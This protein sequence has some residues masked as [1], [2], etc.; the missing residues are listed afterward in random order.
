MVQILVSVREARNLSG[1]DS[2]GTFHR[3]SDLICV[4]LSDVLIKARSI[5]ADGAEISKQVTSAVF[6]ASKY[7]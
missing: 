6:F 1:A 4:G 7:S 3:D 5:G 2:N